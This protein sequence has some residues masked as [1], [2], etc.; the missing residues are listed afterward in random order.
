MTVHPLML[1]KKRGYMVAGPNSSE[2]GLPLYKKLGFKE[3]RK[4]Q[5]YVG[6][7]S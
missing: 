7:F 6:S 4:I 5:N 3:Y 2:L 1:A